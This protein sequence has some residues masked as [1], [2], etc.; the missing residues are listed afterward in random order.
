MLEHE[1]QQTPAVPTAPAQIPAAER[2][3]SAEE[4]ARAV[5]ALED[6]K[7]AERLAGVA[8]IG[9][10]ID[11]LGLDATPEEIWAQVQKQRMQKAAAKT[12][13]A[14]TAVPSALVRYRWRWFILAAASAAAYAHFCS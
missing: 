13:P 6:A 12:T 4:L 10:V 8:P 11:E 3:V 7:A 14:Q 2:R 9:Q 5:S 1:P